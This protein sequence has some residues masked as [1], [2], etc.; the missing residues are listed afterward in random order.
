MQDLRITLIQSDLAWE[1][2]ARNLTLL[3]KLVQTAGETDVIVLPEMFSTGFSMHAEELA[4]KSDGVTT[5]WMQEMAEKLQCC[6]VGS[7]IIEEENAYFN[8]LIWMFPDG[9]YEKYDKRHLFSLGGEDKVFTPGQERLLVEVKGWNICPLICYDLR[10]PVW[11]RYK[12][13][14]DLLLYV[15]SWPE[16][17]AFAWQQL[18]VARAIENQAYVVGVNR[19]GV[20]GNTVYHSGNSALIDPMGQRLWEL[21]HE[22]AVYTATLSASYLE[23]TRSKLPFQNDRDMFSI[24]D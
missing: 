10:F 5:T 13:D 9:H 14:Y 4:E 17:R 1:D 21:E 6:I 15:A 19:I 8:R 22:R 2:A 16:K 18:L 7:V 24:N 3:G 11:S 20:D 12:N 23:E